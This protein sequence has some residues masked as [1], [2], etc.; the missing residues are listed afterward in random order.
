MAI[1]LEAI[2]GHKGNEKPLMFVWS[3]P[4]FNSR[5]NQAQR[6]DQLAATTAHNR[7]KRAQRE[8]R[9][10]YGFRW[11]KKCRSTGTTRAIIRVKTWS[12]PWEIIVSLPVIATMH[13]L[14]TMSSFKNIFKN[15]SWS[16]DEMSTWKHPHSFL[17]W[18]ITAMAFHILQMQQQHLWLNLFKFRDLL[19]DGYQRY[20]IVPAFIHLF[21]MKTW[22][23]IEFVIDLVTCSGSDH[24]RW[25]RTIKV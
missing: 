24:T 2:P 16:R 13:T 6:C 9:C 21:I 25:V 14:E 11:L 1:A 5:A 4:I 17:S 22:Q 3:W 20:P 7:Q 23:R 12:F 10:T 18:I 8:N 19:E 15:A